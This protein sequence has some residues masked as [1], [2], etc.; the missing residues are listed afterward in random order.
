M[1]GPSK[2]TFS[3]GCSDANMNTSNVGFR[4]ALFA[5]LSFFRNS[6]RAGSYSFSMPP[7]TTTTIGQRSHARPTPPR[8][9]NGTNIKTVP[10]TSENLPLPI[11]CESSTSME[12][13]LQTSPTRKQKCLSPLANLAP[14][15][16]IRLW[17]TIAECRHVGAW[18][19]SLSVA[20]ITLD[21][22]NRYAMLSRPGGGCA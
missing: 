4:K 19:F 8:Q 22:L 1:R 5:P 14:G 13:S 17:R 21:V 16:I 10:D 6:L 9:F 7:P 15:A 12:Q 18:E 20:L 2:R 11:G 3:T